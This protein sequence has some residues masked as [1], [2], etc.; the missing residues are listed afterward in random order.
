[1]PDNSAYASK[2]ADAEMAATVRIE[3]RVSNVQYNRKRVNWGR[4][5]GTRQIRLNDCS[6]LHIVT[7]TDINKAVMPATVSVLVDAE[8]PRRYS[9]TWRAELGTKLVKTKLIRVA[10]HS[11]NTGKADMTAKKTAL[12]GT[13][14][15]MVVYANAPADANNSSSIKRLVMKREKLCKRY[16]SVRPSHRF[17]VLINV[18]CVMLPV[19]ILSSK[20]YRAQEENY[21][22]HTSAL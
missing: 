2:L 20:Q 4:I 13:M 5:V 15:N 22:A 6:I 18:M 3:P 16:Q 9:S 19:K 14:A 17:I 8:K 10:V 1:M 11:S 21:G 12:S 7:S